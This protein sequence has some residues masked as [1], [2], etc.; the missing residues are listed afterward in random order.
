MTVIGSPVVRLIAIPAEDL[1]ELERGAVPASL[2]GRALT[3]GLPP[4]HVARRIRS[5]LAAGKPARWVGMCY[6]L[7]ADGCCIGGCGFK[8]VPC[9]REVEV[10]IGLAEAR[11]G[12]GYA[13][14]ALAQV[15]ELARRSDELDAVVAFISSDNSASI[16][17]A[18]RAGFVH[19]GRVLHEDEWQ[20][21]YTLCLRAEDGA[22]VG[23]RD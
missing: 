15:V 16:R 6:I 9:A 18:T 12:Q 2:V 19:A 17:M 14:A 7:D 5:Y 1:P 22:P 10:G 23:A 13:S 3:D 21:R 20:E 11:R 8:D 4:P